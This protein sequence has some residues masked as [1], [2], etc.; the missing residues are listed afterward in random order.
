M[1]NFI[2][3][4]IF[5]FPLISF[6][7]QGTIITSSGGERIFEFNRLS[8]VEKGDILVLEKDGKEFGK[9]LIVKINKTGTKVLAQ[10]V[11]EIFEAKKG[12]TY[13]LR[14]ENASRLRDSIAAKHFGHLF[15]L[16][17]T[18]K[19]Y[20][21][22]LE[23]KDGTSASGRWNIVNS[24]FGIG[25]EHM[26]NM[27]DDLFHVGGGAS[28][29]LPKEVNFTDLVFSDGSV[30]GGVANVKI[31]GILTLFGNLSLNIQDMFDLY[32]GF[33]YSRLTTNQTTHTSFGYQAGIAAM[34]KNI[35]FGATYRINVYED[36]VSIGKERIIAND[37]IGT[38]GYVF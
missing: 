33:N 26:V 35:R 16:D 31:K 20:S 10:V 6:A 17:N 18:N 21:Y 2:F 37:I 19:S 22:L 30:I 27:Y 4:L 7:N 13:N 36:D 5:L 24:G 14:L 12:E 38:V 9:V 11:G 3:F 34:K 29:E 1:R 15:F 23:A 28:Y 25:Y 32:F 8:G